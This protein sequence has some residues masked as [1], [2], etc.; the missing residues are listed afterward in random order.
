[1]GGF[2]VFESPNM[3]VGEKNTSL[4]NLEQVLMFQTG[5]AKTYFAQAPVLGIRID[6]QVD[7][8]LSKTLQGNFN[9]V[10]FEDLPVVI[11]INGMRNLY[12]GCKNNTNGSIS[13]L[14]KKMKASSKKQLLQ[15]T[16]D[17]TTYKGVIVSFTQA[18]TETPGILTYSL[19]IFGVRK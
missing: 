7:F 5:A 19:T 8:S 2:S 15:L 1:M 9:L 17:K 16:I 6:Q 12:T 13:Q 14:Y 18:N 10:T 3:Y 4:T 11:S